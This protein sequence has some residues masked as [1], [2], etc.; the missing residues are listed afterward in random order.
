MENNYT[1]YWEHRIKETFKNKEKSDPEYL[2]WHIISLLLY[3]D[4]HD[5]T[6]IEVFK[7]FKNK[8]NFVKLVS[9][10]DGRNF[11]A[12]TKKDLEEKILLA[13]LYYEKEILKKNWEEI[14]KEFHFNFS[15]VKYG[16]RIKNLDNWIKQKINE[17]I[18]KENKNGSKR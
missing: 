17:I 1:D 14:K 4:A 10:L 3:Q 11:K 5:T 2:L 13:I 6:L 16:I 8:E 9:L 7:L 12:P 15:T 18:R